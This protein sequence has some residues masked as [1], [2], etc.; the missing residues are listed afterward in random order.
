MIASAENAGGMKVDRNNI[1]IKIS[2]YSTLLTVLC[3]LWIFV[4]A[5]WQDMIGVHPEKVISGWIFQG[6]TTCPAIVLY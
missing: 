1:N 6:S 2:A 3:Y 5:H 4:S